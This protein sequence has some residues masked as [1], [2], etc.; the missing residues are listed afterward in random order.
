MPGILHSAGGLVFFRNNG[1]FSQN[2]EVI[3]AAMSNVL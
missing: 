3:L 2:G 1:I